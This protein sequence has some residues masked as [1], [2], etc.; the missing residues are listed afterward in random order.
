MVP[1]R[2]AGR[3]APGLYGGDTPDGPS[4]VGII[5]KSRAI[6][7]PIAH[8]REFSRDSERS[9]CCRSKTRSSSSRG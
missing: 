2:T 7:T 3:P 5:N 9:A 6:S 8:G 1:E 4:K